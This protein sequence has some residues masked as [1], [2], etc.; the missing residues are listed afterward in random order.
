MTYGAYSF[1]PVPL[2]KIAKEFI[3]TDDGGALNEVTKLTLTGT[4]VSSSHL[5][6][7]GLDEAKAA[8]D[9]LRDAFK[10]DHQLL[11]VKCDTV[12]IIRAYPRVLSLNIDESSNNWV[13]T[14]PFSIE[15]EFQTEVN[16]TN[17][18]A[19]NVKQAQEEWQLEFA[20]D[21]PQYS[22]TLVSGTQDATPYSLRLTHT[23][24]AQGMRTYVSGAPTSGSV[25]Q[26]GWQE[27]RDYVISRIGYDSGVIASGASG[28]F[29]FNVAA[30]GVFNHMR[31][32]SFDELNGNFSVSETWLL[33]NSG[34]S[35]LAGN[36]LEDFTVT[37]RSSINDPTTTVSI[38]GSIEGLE[39]RDY[40]TSPNDFSITTEKYASAASYWNVVQ[41][42]LY[43]RA[44]TVAGSLPRSLVTTATN[45]SVGHNKS[46]GTIT[47]SYEFNNSLCF[48]TNSGSLSGQVLS[49][50][51]TITDNNPTD[52]FAKIAILGR[53]A[54]PILQEIST[55]SEKT[56]EVSIEILV[57]PPSTCNISDWIA[58][59]DTVNSNVNAVL[60]TIET[61]LAAASS[62]V[63]KHTDQK[64]WIP[65]QGRYT[66]SIGWT[67][68][69]CTGTADTSVC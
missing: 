2:V 63:F 29:N 42:R 33:M 68:Q 55:V 20:D 65:Q 25:N 4:A 13:Y 1:E 69:S 12:E 21:R 60:C 66:R 61:S 27:A 3:K 62:Q 17:P 24:S 56:K 37:L 14:A 51:I 18:Y 57:I 47:Y 23:V 38:E 36:A 11:L 39:V 40:G 49:E 19:Q 8:I 59:G 54:G 64:S 30:L 16:E 5:A 67:H 48:L 58:L 32:N 43:E 45:S 31:S 52:V 22:E 6:T 26:Y 9:A 46:R 10:T 7:G 53:A 41:G 15:L 35:G 50:I 34:L 28:V 44:N